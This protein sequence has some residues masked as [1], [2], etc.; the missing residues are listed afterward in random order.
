MRVRTLVSLIVAFLLLTSSIGIGISLFVSVG[1][2]APA[3]ATEPRL[4]LQASSVIE[5]NSTLTDDETWSGEILVTG[6]VD[7]PKGITLTINAGTVV[8]FRHYRGYRE[9]YKRLG[10]TVSGTLKA[11]GTPENQIWFTSDAKDAINGDWRMIRFMNAEKESRIK[12]A[13]LEFA[14]QG[15]NMWNSSPTISHSIVRWNNWEGIY[16]ESYCEPLIE[17]CL[18]YE[19]GYNGI[20][21]EQF[22]NATLQYNTIWRSGTNGV[23]IDASTA[24]VEH[25]IVKENHANGLSVDDHGTLI[26]LNNTLQDNYQAG[27][28]CGEGSNTVMA[29]GNK[30]ENNQVK[31][32]YSPS[33]SVQNIEGNGAGE[34][35]YDY[36]DNR[37]Y[38]L[39]YIPGDQQKDRYMYVYPDEDETRRVIKKIG[40]GLGLTWSITWDGKYIWTAA[41][42][43]D[44]YK[45][46]PETGEI[47]AHWIFPGPQAWGMTYD[48]ENLW[49]NDFAEKKVYEMNTNGDVLSSF[50]IP[51]KKGG[52]KGITWDG[53]YLY[54]MGWT[55]PAIYKLDKSGSLIDTI[56]TKGWAG[57]GLTWDGN[58]FWAPGGKGIC[59]IDKD[60]RIVGE[61]YAASEGTWDLAWDGQY[62]WATQR[63]NEN[64]KDAKIYQIEILISRTVG[65]RVNVYP[66]SR[67]VQYVSSSDYFYVNHGF[68]LRSW[69]NLTADERSAFLDSQQTNITL[70]TSAPN[71]ENPP[72]THYTVYFNET[73]EMHNQFFFQFQPGDLALGTY[74]FTVT[75][76]R[77]AA[78]NPP[79]YTAIHF[80]NTI[81]L[82]VGVN[83]TVVV[84]VNVTVDPTSDLELTFSNVIAAGSATTYK[85]S[86]VE[87]PLSADFVGQ[88]YDV[89][90]TASYSG[91]V[92]VS[93][94]YDDTN[95]ALGRESILQM[96][97]YTPILGDMVNYG[98][99]NILDIGFVAKCF[100]TKLGDPRWNATADIND[101]GN[102][103]ILDIS[104]CAKN[105]GKTAEWTNITTNVDTELNIIHGETTHFSFI[106]IH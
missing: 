2:V 77:A 10:M 21:M 90:V 86:T 91:N 48:G 65:A 64:W 52:A 105:F 100:G 89:R 28:Q 11:V 8:K 40:E 18:I 88:Y 26:A 63:T 46:D 17:Y 31:I 23:H 32:A 61:I 4:S 94:A 43:G 13:I 53:E 68:L 79:D 58:Y 38:E 7:V 71:F 22:N 16:L 103:N 33:D 87:A 62:L 74:S 27:I 29:Q 69:S 42:W 36:P 34:I 83:I 44:V 37:P 14:Q 104:T 59:R 19:N 80:Q 75:W 3:S 78:A 70:Q 97:Q 49:I 84:G 24:R 56:E 66:G 67:S 98:Q 95:M 85:T 101:D 92:A 41:L 82:V 12:Y 54:L 106:G 15:I 39:G 93:L 47:R 81:T 45:L 9:V 76:F 73:D 102:I 96:M 5:K 57:G 35:I 20:A 51:D 30:F 72:M 55:T 6:D 50:E 25:S 99:V 1:F 60:G